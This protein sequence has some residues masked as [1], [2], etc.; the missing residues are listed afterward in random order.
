MHP[1]RE[2]VALYY[3]ANPDQEEWLIANF[4][5][6]FKAYNNKTNE[7]EAGKDVVMYKSSSS[8]PSHWVLLEQANTKGGKK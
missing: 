7:K 8:L 6:S 4:S 2:N 3:T 1:P 5:L